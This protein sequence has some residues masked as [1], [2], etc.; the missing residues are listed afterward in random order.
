MESGDTESGLADSGDGP[1]GDDHSSFERSLRVW[2]DGAFLCSE[3]AAADMLAG[4]GGAILFTSSSAAV[5]SDGV[6]HSSA[7]FGARGLARS[8]AR[9]LWP[10]GIYVATVLVNGSVG[11]PDQREWA[12]H[13][14]GEWIHPDRVAETYWHVANQH[15]S[16]WTLELDIRVHAADINFS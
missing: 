5:R 2:A 4:D 7:G 11:R 3:Q 14:D 12:D 15:P 1:L 9:Q 13:P 16:A 8:L 10:E 6:A